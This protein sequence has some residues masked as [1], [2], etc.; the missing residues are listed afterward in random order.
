MAFICAS[1][2]KFFSSAQQLLKAFF[3]KRHRNKCYN[4]I[5]RH[6]QAIN[7]QRDVINCCTT[8]DLDGKNGRDLKMQVKQE[9][10]LT[11]VRECSQSLATAGEMAA[12]CNHVLLTF[13][14]VHNSSS[15]KAPRCRGRNRPR[16]FE[17]LPDAT[18]QKGTKQKQTSV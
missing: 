16:G 4:S 13:T 8:F 17:T 6:K 1:F 5:S 3:Q 12:C 15:D 9:E 11:R 18:R 14:D 7:C 10:L 2:F